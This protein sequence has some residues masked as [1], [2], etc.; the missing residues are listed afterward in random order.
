MDQK[1]RKQKRNI[2]KVTQEQSNQFQECIV[3]GQVQGQPIDVL[4]DSGATHSMIGDDFLHKVP[5][6]RNRMVNI[7]QPLTAIA[8]NGTTVTYKSRLDFGI[9][10]NG[11]EYNVK[12]LYSPLISYTLVLGLDFLRKYEILFNFKTRNMTGRGKAKVKALDDI[13][14]PPNSEAVIWGETDETTPGDAIVSNSTILPQLNVYV[15]GAVVKINR[16]HN[17]VPVRVMNPT[18]AAK[19]IRK[20]TKLAEIRLLTEK[21][22]LTACSATEHVKQNSEHVPREFRSQFD[23]SRSVFTTE[24][25]RKLYDLLWEYNDIFSRQDAKLGKTDLL[26]FEIELK[27]DAVP[28]K[29][30]PYRSNP[31]VRQEVRRQVQEM[32]DKDIIEPSTSNFGSPV[33]LVSKPDGSSRFCVDYR[34]LN[35]M[36]KVDCH[37]IARADDCLES[38]GASGAKY[39]SSLDLESGYWQLPVHPDSRPYTAF[40]THDGLY[41]CK[42]MSFGLVNA[43]S[44]FTRLMTRVLQGLNW[45]ICLVYIDDIII[46][47]KSFEEH[48]K[49]MRLIFDRFRSAGL[50]V[51]PKKSFFGQE[52]IKFLG[53]YVS[54]KGI[55]PMEEKCKVI[56]NFPRPKKVKDVRSFL[57]LAGY[58][59]RFIKNFSKISGPLVDLTKHETVFDWTSSCEEAFNTLKE[60]LMTPPILAY[61]DYNK[62]YILQTDASGESLGMIL[63]QK[64]GSLERVIAYAGKRL[65]AS[66]KNYSTT[67]KEALGVIEGLKHFDPYLRGNHVTI[68]TDHSALIWLLAQKQPKG[69]IARWIAYLQQFNYTIEHKAGKKHTNADALS[70]REYESSENTENV[71]DDEKILPPLRVM[72][73]KR[74]PQQRARR[75]RRKTQQRPEYKYPD[76]Q[77]TPERVR[78]CQC[79]DDAIRGMTEYLKNAKLP[80]DERLAREIALESSNCVLEDWI[81]YFV[82]DRKSK[83]LHAKKQV[84]ELHLCLVVPKELR[85]DVLTAM[86]GDLPGGHYG[87]QRTYTTLRLKYFWKGMYNDCKNWVLSCL[88]CNQRKN[89]VRPLKAELH[90]LPAVMTNERWAMDIVTLPRTE[91]GNRYVLTFTEYNTRYVEAFALPETSSK[92][93]ARTLVDEIC[94]RY[95]APQTLLSDLGANLISEVMAET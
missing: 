8:I 82:L 23:L 91:R 44:V 88:S 94:F 65:T 86:H 35:S 33:L 28:F 30:R 85:H 13:T 87:T 69:R 4:I 24:Q 48:L 5:H 83:D 79:K 57:G 56:Q 36:T 70:R 84:E 22:R 60:K 29:A 72:A 95:G 34:K 63:A 14:I 26:Q 2:N 67:E 77:W 10:L 42:R 40:V 66:E 1:H 74:T 78:D 20:N 52:R 62:P 89:P 47:S 19:T 49:R 80:I 6:L 58:Y 41:Q 9:E 71:I 61:P 25:R 27:D 46:F 81:L 43:P 32:L 55:E 45:E 75:S 54:E 11:H 18:A 90:P 92:T 12:A 50:T 16:H 38:L 3:T 68:V 21:E 15:A 37:P 17:K 73:A 93:I 76:I 53:H 31:H 64:Q 59:R 39:F 51:K 7:K